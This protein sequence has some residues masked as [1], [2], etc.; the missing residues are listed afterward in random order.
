MNFL[1]KNSYDNHSSIIL[2]NF[3]LVLKI[4]SDNFTQFF[5]YKIDTIRQAFGNHDDFKSVSHAN[6]GKH[7]EG[8]KRNKTRP[9]NDMWHENFLFLCER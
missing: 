3:E 5:I 2:D 9:T 7:A 4:S 6:V 1:N 8:K